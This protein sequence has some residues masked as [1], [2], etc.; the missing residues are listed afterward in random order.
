[1]LFTSS[2]SHI[3]LS[4]NSSPATLAIAQRNVT[5]TVA[6]PLPG[7]NDVVMHCE[8]LPSNEVAE[9]G[10]IANGVNEA[11]G[12]IGEATAT[13]ARAVEHA[14][15]AV[16]DGAVI[17]GNMAPA[18]RPV[19]DVAHALTEHI[20]TVAHEVADL[21]ENP[22]PRDFD[23]INTRIAAGDPGTDRR[24]HTVTRVPKPK[25]K[26]VHVQTRLGVNKA[27]RTESVD[28][29]AHSQT[30]QSGTEVVSAS[31]R[32]E[33]QGIRGRVRSQSLESMRVP[34]RPSKLHH[35]DV[36]ASSQVPVT[37]QSQSGAYTASVSHKGN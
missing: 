25:S 26:N 16:A 12:T 18:V 2:F 35:G 14:A 3:C 10:L 24:S 13:A 21:A 30:V 34:V 7:D 29:P 15:D 23:R 37:I 19:T 6:P 27:L 9:A 11:F 36:V 28:I 17:V 1:M 8:D 4:R 32:V 20:A 33:R 5:L 31:A 22:V